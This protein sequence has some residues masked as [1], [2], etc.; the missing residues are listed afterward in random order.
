MTQVG[1]RWDITFEG[2]ITRRDL[3]KLERVLKVEFAKAQ[4]R[5]SLDRVR[6]RQVEE[7][8]TEKSPKTPKEPVVQETKTDARSRT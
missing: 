8:P 7:T 6:A 2:V 3:M 1:P 5:H 4:R